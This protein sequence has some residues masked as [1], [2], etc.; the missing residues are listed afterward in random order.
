MRPNQNDRYSAQY[1]QG[2]GY[3]GDP[4][5]QGGNTKPQGRGRVQ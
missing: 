4:Y 3:Q 2:Y 1:Y 5:N